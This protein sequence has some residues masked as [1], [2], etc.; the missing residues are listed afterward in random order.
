MCSNLIICE[1]DPENTNYVFTEG[2]KKWLQVSSDSTDVEFM[3]DAEEV[4]EI[5]ENP[6]AKLENKV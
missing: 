6:F 3:R 5:R 2:A 4:K 1:T